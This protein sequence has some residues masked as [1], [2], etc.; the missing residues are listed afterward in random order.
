MIEDVDYLLDNCE[1]DS[2]LFYIDSTQRD[3]KFYPTPSE[4][5]VTFTTPFRLVYGIE[6]LDAAMPTTEYNVD[7]S[8][9][10]LAMTLVGKPPLK[11][12]NLKEGLIEV[13]QAKTFC[14]LFEMNSEN[15]ILMVTEALASS[16][17]I[18]TQYPRVDMDPLYD[19]METHY[20]M[21]RKVLPDQLLR[22]LQ[23]T[24]LEP[25]DFMFKVGEDPYY[26]RSTEVELINILQNRDYHLSKIGGHVYDVV[27]FEV[28]AVPEEKYND[29][30]K[31]SQEYIIEFK[32]YFRSINIGNYDIS[33]LRVQLNSVYNG[34]DMFVE[35]TSQIERQ[36]GMLKYLSTSLIVLN[37]TKSTMAKNLGFDTLPTT[38]ESHLYDYIPIGNNKRVFISNKYDNDSFRWELFPPGIINLLGERYLILR[39]KE[40]EDHVL[41]SYAYTSYVPG[42]GL[43]KLAASYNDITNLR[44]DFVSLIRKP[45]HPIGKLSKMTFRFE[46]SEG[47]PYDFKGVNH[48]LLLVVKFY[49]PSP[50][51]RIPKSILNPSYD[52][53]FIKYMSNHTTIAYRED[54]DEETDFDTRKFNMIYKQEM[55]KYNHSSSEDE[56]YESDDSELPH[57]LPR[58][59]LRIAPR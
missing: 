9:K 59:P 13:S 19:F 47:R 4:Y 10:S 48:Q 52:P 46:T 35:S 54:S 15:F 41:G 28:Y 45:F 51:K 7:N 56:E 3:K 5:T 43:F 27:Y 11:S 44:F 20:V 17:N 18:Q 38:T 21:V 2:M 30:I 1:K 29:E 12:R 42:I 33:S 16:F 57:E 32:N 23:D 8:N 37:A 53:D 6:I 34:V 24:K 25:D 55:E 49:V 40:I 36:Q 50:K 58:D 39:C 22:P 14:R 26:V 31:D